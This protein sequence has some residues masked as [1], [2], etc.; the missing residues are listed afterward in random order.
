MSVE[1]DNRSYIETWIERF[2]NLK[3]TLLIR[4]SNA[5]DVVVK[6][7]H[8]RRKKSGIFLLRSSLGLARGGGR[9]EEKSAW[10]GQ[11]HPRSSF[12]LESRVHDT[13]RID[14]RHMP[15]FRCVFILT[16]HG[17]IFVRWWRMLLLRKQNVIKCF[18]NADVNF[19]TMK[20]LC[21]VFFL[22]LFCE[23][24]IYFWCLY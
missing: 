12:S 9:G 23:R 7:K 8:M 3:R 17:F 16:T 18:L 14:F 22:D 15:A 5:V 20:F 19:M 2:W 13:L 1:N 24:I 21:F 10:G 6:Q 4:I 11:S